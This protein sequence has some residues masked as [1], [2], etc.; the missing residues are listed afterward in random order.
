MDAKPSNIGAINPLA[1]K[2]EPNVPKDVEIVRNADGR[3][4]RRTV[5]ESG[6]I[7]ETHVFPGDHEPKQQIARPPS[8]VVQPETLLDVTSVPT[9]AEM[10]NQSP[11]DM[12]SPT[13]V[14]EEGVG[15][16][17]AD[18]GGEEVAEAS[19]DTNGEGPAGDEQPAANPPPPVRRASR[20]RAKGTGRG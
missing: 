19:P 14:G 5:F 4:V 1:G 11:V 3:L 17:A 10:G 9:D 13:T 8:V 18:Q 20:S 16:N 2:M 15:A 12:G 7:R 6:S